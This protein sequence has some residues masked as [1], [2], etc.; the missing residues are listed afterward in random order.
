MASSKY[1]SGICAMPSMQSIRY[2]RFSSSIVY[3]SFP[4]HKARR[5]VVSRLQLH[6][7]HRV[8]LCQLPDIEKQVSVR[9]L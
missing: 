5:V 6:L 1:L 9:T 4:R 7:Q 8:C 2:R 3:R